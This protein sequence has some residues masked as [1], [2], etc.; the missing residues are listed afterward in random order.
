MYFMRGLGTM[1]GSPVGGKILGESV[2][3]NYRNVIWFDA[4]LLGGVG[5]VQNFDSITH[6][7]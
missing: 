3:A 7:F 2:L 4:A 1:F 6:M 5:E